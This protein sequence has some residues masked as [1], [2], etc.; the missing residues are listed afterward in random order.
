MG[1]DFDAYL[2]ADANAH[3]VELYLAAQVD[4]DALLSRTRPLFFSVA[5]TPD[6]YYAVRNAFNEER[7]PGTRAAYFLYLN[8]FGHHGIC[9]YNKSGKFNVPFGYNKSVPTLPDQEL[10]AAADKL[11]RASLLCSDF[12]TAFMLATP[13]DV[14]YCDPPYVDQDHAASFRSYVAGAFGD[15]QQRELAD[16][17]RAAAKRGIPVVVSNHLTDYSRELYHGAA[18]HE[19]EVRRSI[20]AGKSTQKSAHEGLFVFHPA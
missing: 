18:V 10:R 12:T 7:D 1:T 11:K 17:A 13:G 5:N 3:L 2:L 15:S 16:L 9:R 8:K 6:V 19:I 4:V 20:G 14:I